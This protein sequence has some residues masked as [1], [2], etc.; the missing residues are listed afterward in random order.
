MRIYLAP[1]EG[2]TGLYTG[3]HTMRFFI[4]DKYFTPFLKP[5]TKQD[6]T[7]KEKNE[8]LPG[9]NKNMN[10]VPQILTNH[11]DGFINTSLKLKNYGYK[12]VNLNL[13]CPSKTVV[14]KKPGIW[15]FIP[16]ETFDGISG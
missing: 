8:I 1:M 16:D 4:T 13:G 7:T 3:T 15:I 14:S 11:A 10:V 2:V 12:E 6:L 5:H 9:N